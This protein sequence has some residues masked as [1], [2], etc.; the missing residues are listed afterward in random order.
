MV[1]VQ[2]SLPCVVGIG[3]VLGSTPPEAEF[4]NEGEVTQFIKCATRKGCK[5]GFV[6][7]FGVRAMPMRSASF[8]QFITGKAIASQIIG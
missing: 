6:G 3:I 7:C 1:E 2:M 5:A 4:P 8:F